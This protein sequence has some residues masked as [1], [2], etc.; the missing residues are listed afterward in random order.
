[1]QPRRI[2]RELALLSIGQLSASAELTGIQ[3]I[4][5][6]MNAAVRTLSE[7]IREV[8]EAASADL[9]Q[10]SDRLL[11]S[12]LQTAD[13]EGARAMVQDAISQTEVVINRLGAAVDLPL[14]IQVAQNPEVQDFALSLIRTCRQ[15]RPDIDQILSKALVDWQLSRLAQIDRNI[16]RLAV[17]EMCFL[18]IPQRVAINEAV[19]LAKR[20]SSEDGH[21]FINGVL[22]RVTQSRA[23]DSPP[24]TETPTAR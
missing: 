5:A 24:P 3:E 7:E 12:K 19:E 23:G 2:A 14:F 6:A 1:M 4:Q 18:E 15:H 21:R 16:L 8:L 17:A 20:Y 13:L 11:A 10:S 22:R 9:K